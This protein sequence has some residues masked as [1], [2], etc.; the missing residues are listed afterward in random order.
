M[1]KTTLFLL[2]FLLINRFFNQS[3]A[4]A[5]AVYSDKNWNEKLLVLEKAFQ[6]Q[7]FADIPNILQLI[8]E[9]LESNPSLGLQYIYLLRS[10]DQSSSDI[11]NFYEL[12][13]IFYKGDYQKVIA[14]SPS[15]LDSRIS[16]AWL[17]KA[18][19]YLIR[20]HYYLKNFTAA[21]TQ[22]RTLKRKHRYS[23]DHENL[24]KLVADSYFQLQDSKNYYE[25]LEDIASLYPYSHDSKNAFNNLLDAESAVEFGR[26]YVF[27]YRLLK[28][29]SWAASEFD[30]L[31][32]FIT[33]KLDQ[34]IHYHKRTGTL[35][36]IEKIKVLIKMRFYEEATEII[37]TALNNKD[38]SNKGM[39]DR[40][41]QNLLENLGKIYIRQGRPVE[42]LHT[43]SNL[44]LSHPRYRTYQT[45]QWIADSLRYANM[46]KPAAKIYHSLYKQTGN[47]YAAWNAFW[48]YYRATDYENAL[49]FLENRRF[50]SRDGQTTAT[51]LYWRAKILE[52]QGH[53]TASQELVAKLLQNY[54]Q[55]I[56]ATL[57]VF[58]NPN[59][60]K[61]QLK[62]ASLIS[63]RLKEEPSYFNTNTRLAS[64]SGTVKIAKDGSFFS[65]KIPQLLA[66][67][68]YDPARSLLKKAIDAGQHSK[69]EVVRLQRLLQ[70]ANIY[71]PRMN[72]MR[73]LKVY[74]N[75]LPQD[76]STYHAHLQKNQKLWK[77]YYPKAYEKTVTD[78]SKKPFDILMTY[79]IMRA[80]SFYREDA[81]SGVGA[82]GLMQIMPQTGYRI[83]KEIQDH[84]FNSHKLVDPTENLKYANFYI[85]KL[86]DHYDQNFF[87]AL[88]AYN[89]GP[90]YVQNWID[91][92]TNCEVDEFIE[93]IP[94]RE[95]R[96]YVKKVA[97]NIQHYS[98]IY[99]ASWNF[100]TWPKVEQLAVKTGLIY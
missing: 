83:S 71:T 79:G 45:K 7:N 63:A 78:Y 92:C 25:T 72:W 30:D 62:N 2:V 97:Q 6:Q 85:T 29:L 42:A 100:P 87:L 98:Y 53:I 5:K 4:D 84:D 9:V 26:P 70:M 44:H 50:Q 86:L 76:F 39:T 88:A 34:P 56:Y 61:N 16:D 55:S 35:D 89:A 13:G 68:L 59:L 10:S 54:G 46:H 77:L 43:F 47:K 91:S 81:R 1:S 18:Y 11:L 49:A 57:A 36:D 58:K 41:E 65:E 37:Q 32:D 75:H 40:D 28:K 24:L 99:D 15:V 14:K 33:T 74:S 51:S 17:R 52:K 66:R 38:L 69:E 22:Y 67:K 94:F 21:V 93:S 31:K 48:C 95:T 20:S 64:S 3:P 8:S 12:K 60:Q 23:N 80:E 73:Q 96:R 90:H 27:S 19:V 82:A